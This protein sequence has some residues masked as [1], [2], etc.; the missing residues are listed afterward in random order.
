[1]KLYSAIK[2]SQDR[3]VEAGQLAFEKGTLTIPAPHAMGFGFGT[4]S[5]LAAVITFCNLFRRT[6]GGGGEGRVV[7]E[8]IH[9]EQVNVVIPSRGERGC[10]W[11][12][13]DE[14]E[15]DSIHSHSSESR[16][17]HDIE[18]IIA[19]Q[20]RK[21]ELILGTIRAPRAPPMIGGLEVKEVLLAQLGAQ[22]ARHDPPLPPRNRSWMTPH[23]GSWRDSSNG[24]SEDQ[25]TSIA[26]T[27]ERSIEVVVNYPSEATLESM[28]GRCS[29]N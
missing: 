11:S 24:T 17:A 25:I 16:P 22:R 9:R 1:M 20:N 28:I 12:T 2:E 8:E 15:Y 13:D 23:A 3:S 29:R 26:L 18:S 5:M 7:E 14:S 21:M 19:N 6:F 27:W 10:N 4:L